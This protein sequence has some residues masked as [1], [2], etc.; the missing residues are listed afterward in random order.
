MAWRVSSS[1]GD[2]RQAL[3]VVPGG[4]EFLGE[5]AA[6][7][8]EEGGGA[9]GDIGDL[10]GEN[11]FGPWVAAKALEDGLQSLGDD[12]LGEGAWGVVGPGAAAFVGGLGDEGACGDGVRAGAAV[13]AF[14]E[15][16]E[17]VVERAGGCEGLGG[18][19]RGAGCRRFP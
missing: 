10:E 6:G 14:V 7:F 5:L 8:D 18:G 13:D 4:G 15:G 16:G 9:D 3:V 17:E 1:S 12:G 19:I 11:L 2:I